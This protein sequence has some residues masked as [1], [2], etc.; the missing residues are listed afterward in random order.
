MDKLN[1]IKEQINYVTGIAYQGRN[2]DELQHQKEINKYE[3]SEWLTFL[4]A[5]DK[6]LKL[7]GAK[8]KGV[9]IFKRLASVDE[10]DKN[11]K[12]KTVDR[13]TGFATVFNLD[14]TKPNTKICKQ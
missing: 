5:R 9:S 13:P 11:G 12:I 8:G 10:K 7:V 2:Q 3:S 6:D 4:Q 14:L 1:I